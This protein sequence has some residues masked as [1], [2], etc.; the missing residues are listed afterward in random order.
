MLGSGFAQRGAYWFDEYGADGCFA[1]PPGADAGV[2]AGACAAAG[3]DAC[4]R[5]PSELAPAPTLASMF[6]GSPIFSSPVACT[7]SRLRRMTN[8]E[9]KYRKSIAHM[10]TH[11]RALVGHVRQAPTHMHAP[12]LS[13]RTER[14]AGR[15]VLAIVHCVHNAFLH[16]DKRVLLELPSSIAHLPNTKSIHAPATFIGNSTRSHQVVHLGRHHRL[17]EVNSVGYDQSVPASFVVCH[18]RMRFVSS[19]GNLSGWL[20]PA[21]P[22]GALDWIFLTFKTCRVDHA[23]SA[24]LITPLARCVGRERVCSR[25]LGS[26]PADA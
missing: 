17:H 13:S 19:S 2:C 11:T 20:P 16:V 6:C 22:A 15:G 14:A 8:L 4:G 18:L 24:L 25:D 26:T 3:A 21:P 9:A 1:A 7:T 10:R 23:A 5:A 12:H